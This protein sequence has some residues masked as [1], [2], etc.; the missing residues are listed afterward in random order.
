MSLLHTLSSHCNSEWNVILEFLNFL[1]Y[2]FSN[3]FNAGDIFIFDLSCNL[4]HGFLRIFDTLF[5]KS[6]VKLIEGIV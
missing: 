3:L 6:G 1:L 2:H 4:V 5:H